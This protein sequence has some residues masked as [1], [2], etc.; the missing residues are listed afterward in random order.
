MA[1]NSFCKLM[2]KHTHYYTQ[3]IYASISHSNYSLAIHYCSVRMPDDLLNCQSLVKDE[4]RAL[5]SLI[6]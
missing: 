3:S 5:V 1:R 2:K 4:Y 6:D